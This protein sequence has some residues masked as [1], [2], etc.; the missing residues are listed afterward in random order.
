MSTT[1]H[2]GIPG[3]DGIAGPKR[4]EA[5]ET[6][7]EAERSWHG[8][9]ANSYHEETKQL[10][11]AERMGLPFMPQEW[12]YPTIDM[13]GAS[14]LDIGGGAYSLLLKCR[15]VNGTVLDPCE[16]PAWTQDRYAAAGIHVVP[17]AAEDCDDWKGNLFSE[18]WLYN[19]LQHTR[20][21]G[22]VV[23]LARSVGRVVRVYE[24]IGT[25]VDP[26]HPH[27]FT[28]VQLETAFGGPGYVETYQNTQAF[29]GVFRG[30][31]WEE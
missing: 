17:K 15:R 2:P 7:Q 14:V 29:Y 13:G 8:T 4:G 23:A 6:A 11:Y 31:V 9:C 3:P 16:Y 19:V 12:T 28:R 10:H 26:C 5:W 20:Q 22:K 18:V 1:G 30:E 27:T 25:A 24:W 21:P